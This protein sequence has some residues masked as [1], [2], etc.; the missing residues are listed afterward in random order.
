MPLE[1]TVIDS[2][3]KT[4]NKERS[5]SLIKAINKIADKDTKESLPVV[6]HVLKIIK[7]E[8]AKGEQLPDVVKNIAFLDEALHI[9]NESDRIQ[10]LSLLELRRE[11]K[12]IK[13]ETMFGD[14]D[15]LRDNARLIQI[16]TEATKQL[17]DELVVWFKGM[18]F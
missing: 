15:K 13:T 17:W 1:P 3:R 2:L 11:L 8:L 18:Y 14:L 12:E 16:N 7:N 6:I 5:L 4:I 10:N 9:L